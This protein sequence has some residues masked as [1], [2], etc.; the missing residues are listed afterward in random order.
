MITQKREGPR[1]NA[2]ILFFLALMLAFGI[3]QR[4]NSVITDHNNS[5]HPLETFD[6]R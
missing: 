2:L 6:Y 3:G 4:F 1:T 5:D